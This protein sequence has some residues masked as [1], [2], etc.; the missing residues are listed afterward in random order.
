MASPT[1]KFK[2]GALANLPQLAVG[3]P[4]F[5]TDT[6]QLY[7][8][9]HDGTNR[10]IG[11]DQFFN[12]ESPTEGGGIKLFEATNNGENFV[13]LQSPDSLSADIS[14]TLP[15]TDGT[16]DQVLQ[17]DGSGVLSFGDVKLSVIDIDGA[18]DIDA[19]ITDNDLFIIDDGGIGTN[20]K[21]AASRL[22]TY[23]IGGGGN[24]ASFT[25]VTVGSAVTISSGGIN[26]SSGV[27]TATS[28]VGDLTGDV[29]AGDGTV[30]LQNGTN[31][32]DAIFTGIVTGNVTGNLTGIA[33]TA[34]TVD[35]NDSG[36]Q[37]QSVFL[38]FSD[39][40]S[41]GQGLETDGGL[42]YNPSTGIL[43]TTTFS[44]NLEGGVT[45]DVTGTATTANN[46]SDAANITA[47]IINADRLSGSY[48]ISI[49][50]AATTATD[51]QKIKTIKDATGGLRYLTFV[52][53]NN[54]NATA[55]ELKTDSGVTYNPGADVLGITGNITVSGTV[56]GRDVEDDG[57]AGDNLI[58][59]TGVERDAVNLGEFNGTTISDNVTIKTALQELE[60]GLAGVAATFAIDGD[61]GSGIVTTGTTFHI[62]GTDFE[63][64]TVASN[65][66]LTIGLPDT[67]NV[68][69]ELNVPR[70]DTGDVRAS[71][72]TPA[73]TIDDST[74]RVTA[75][76]PVLLN[77]D[78]IASQ[79]A[80]FQGI[81]TIGDAVSDTVNILAKV[82]SNLVPST[83]DGSRDIGSPTHNWGDGY[84]DRLSSDSIN[85]SGFAT[86]GTFKGTTLDLTGS[87]VVG[88][89]LTVTGDLTVNGTLTS[90]D[91]EDLKVTSPII[92]LGLE[93]LT[94]DTTQPPSFQTTYNSGLA[95]YYNSV[96]VSSDNAKVAAVVAKVKQGGDFR[97]GFATDVTVGQVTIGSTTFDSIETINHFADIEARSLFITDCAGTSAVIECTGT[98]RFLSN[99]IVDG[100]TFT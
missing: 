58:T 93:R 44:G 63:I 96:G 31:G 2:R 10:L 23:I 80:T 77:G 5:T 87:A 38:V 36:N 69:T 64:E 33:S 55:E 35:L 66:T 13:E 78:L 50:G 72:G 46:L 49:T 62:E 61:T 1:L 84:I 83:T 70:V 27:V 99:I 28:F 9:S 19:D 59:L 79:G 14:F 34:T 68:T 22:K 18:D 21:A 67:V 4:G 65:N 29:K 91:V 54:D 90:V 48:N 41:G 57:Q 95:L 53:S 39:G 52:D 6:Y 94:D 15:G 40:A 56:D 88:G 30:V 71:D 45:G 85:V 42:I 60:T 25:E 11:G 17:T 16:A 26:I 8:G 74:G 7:I 51:A 3:E 12:L 98:E 73:L 86:A 100:G 89:A 82:D 97:I 24:N 20:R 37:N 32:N 75:S 76:G 43:T 81:T 47:G 92:E